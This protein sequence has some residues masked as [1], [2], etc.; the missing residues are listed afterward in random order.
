MKQKKS[1]TFNYY[2]LHKHIKIKKHRGFRQVIINLLTNRNKTENKNKLLFVQ[3]R[4]GSWG[5]T[6]QGIVFQDLAENLFETLVRNLGEEL[7]FKGLIV[8][9]TKPTFIPQA[10]LFN[11][12]R[13]VYDALRADDEAKKKRPTKGKVYHLAMLSYEGPDELPVNIGDPSS[14]IRDYRW[15]N[16]DEGRELI[17]QN[18][19]LLKTNKAFSE[20]TMDFHKAFYE[21]IID[22]YNHIQGLYLKDN[23]YQRALF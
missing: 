14:V 8:K 15:I 19:D 6:R 11:V 9:E 10:Y 1:H 12:E 7:G 17:S 20:A 3:E 5:F 18:Y 16:E 4:G 23:L 21:K 22:I 13:Q 2:F